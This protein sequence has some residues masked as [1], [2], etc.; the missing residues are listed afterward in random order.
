[1]DNERKVIDC[2][3]FPDSKCTVAISGSEKEVLA[4]AV[5]HAVRDHGHTESPE[6][7]EKLR[8]LLEAQR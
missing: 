4:M 3:K 8:G 1:M 7:R 6:L 5:Q 2:R